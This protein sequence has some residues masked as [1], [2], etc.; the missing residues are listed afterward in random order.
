MS[1]EKPTRPP[2][3]GQAE[4]VVKTFDEMLD[5]DRMPDDGLFEADPNCEHNLISPR[6]GGVKC[7]KCPGWFCY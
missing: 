2:T 7:T 6:G 4:E 3:E 5:E 1:T